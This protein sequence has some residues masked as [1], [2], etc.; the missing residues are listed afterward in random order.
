[1]S[2]DL[3]SV[4]SQNEASRLSTHSNK[5]INSFLEN[6]NPE[7]FKKSGDLGRLAFDASLAMFHIVEA[8]PHWDNIPKNPCPALQKEWNVLNKRFD[9]L[10]PD[11]DDTDA[12]VEQLRNPTGEAKVVSDKMQ[13]IQK[14]IEAYKCNLEK[15]HPQFA[16]LARQWDCDKISEIKKR[17][18]AAVQLQREYYDT[19]WMGSVSKFFLKLTGQ[20][21]NGDTAAIQSALHKLYRWDFEQPL[22]NIPAH[23]ESDFQG[24][25]PFKVGSNEYAKGSD[26][27]SADSERIGNIPWLRTSWVKKHLK[28][29]HLY[30][31]PLSKQVTIVNVPAVK[32]A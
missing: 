32:T 7:T 29:D 4:L 5:R 25:P 26:S 11:N 23:A 9:K 24:G 12:F 28:T 27:T 2:G 6:A 30:N 18:G 20:W 13:A 15:T 1:M 8:N 14:R 22:C 17:L 10:V 21:N 16:K 19:T 31:E 3:S